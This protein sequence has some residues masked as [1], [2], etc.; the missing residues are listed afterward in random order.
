MNREKRKAA[1]KGMY[2]KLR[3]LG[4]VFGQR[5]SYPDEIVEFIRAQFPDEDMGHFDAQSSNK[6]KETS[7]NLSGFLAVEWGKCSC[8]T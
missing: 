8:E 7:E 2:C 3:E 6:R 4:L 1:Y 5:V